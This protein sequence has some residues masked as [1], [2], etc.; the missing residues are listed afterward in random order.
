MKHNAQYWIGFFQDLKKDQ[1]SGDFIDK[2]LILSGWGK[3]GKTMEKWK[4]DPNAVTH[5][6]PGYGETKGE[7]YLKA[8]YKNQKQT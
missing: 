2:N 4:V 5:K 6:R 8:D 1:F 7:L 3:K